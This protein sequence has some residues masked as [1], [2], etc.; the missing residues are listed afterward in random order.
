M[1]QDLYYHQMPIA[2]P[3]YGFSTY[4]QP[5]YMEQ[6]PWVIYILCGRSAYIGLGQI[7]SY[8]GTRNLLRLEGPLDSAP[9]AA[10]MTGCIAYA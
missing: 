2:R 5:R 4:G 7:L 9:Q 8:C 3:P 10:S 1:T 6:L